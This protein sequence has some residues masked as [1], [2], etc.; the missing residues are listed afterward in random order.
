[1]FKS[2]IMVVCILSLSACG[3]G[4]FLDLYAPEES[5]LN[6]MKITDEASNSVIGNNSAGGLGFWRKETLPLLL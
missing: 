4:K 3:S 2:G 5:G 6:V 1:M